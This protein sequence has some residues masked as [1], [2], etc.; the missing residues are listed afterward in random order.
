MNLKGEKTHSRLCEAE[1]LYSQN[2]YTH[3]IID[4][5]ATFSLS[6]LLAVVFV[7]SA[8]AQTFSNNT[9]P[10]PADYFGGSDRNTYLDWWAV[11]AGNSASGGY[12]NSIFLPSN[13]DPSLGAAVHWS[14]QGDS[15]F[16]AVAA[17]ATGWV[18]FGLSEDGGM[19]GS[20]VVLFTAAEPNVLVD[21]YILEE[22]FPVTADS[23]P[24]NWSLLYSQTGGGFLIWEGTRL[25][26]TGDPQDRV[27]PNDADA[28]TPPS[29]I[30]ATW[31]ESQD[32]SYYGTT[33][34]VSGAVRWF[35]GSTLDLESVG[36]DTGRVVDTGRV[37]DCLDDDCSDSSD[38]LS[39]SS[40]SGD[41]ITDDCNSSD[42]ESNSG[43]GDNDTADID[44]VL[45]ALTSSAELVTPCLS[46]LAAASTI[47]AML[48]L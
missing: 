25:L 18:G 14:I 47:S 28:M 13:S 29:R 6:C 8:T 33:N 12:T 24:N 48:F 20:D 39:D 22:G 9:T 1:L 45:S 36:A 34:S 19:Q 44:S 40:D 31:G 2:H 21:S 27:I 15:V 3:K 42:S 32:V 23:G 5:M 26:N 10:L 17:R 43:D 7:T 38:S 4:M 16:L 37:G 35:D 11:N 46:F 30:T 41:C